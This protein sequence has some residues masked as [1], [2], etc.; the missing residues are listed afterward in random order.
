MTPPRFFA[1][2]LAKGAVRTPLKVW[3]GHPQDPDTGETLTERPAMWRGILDGEP[4][5]MYPRNGGGF[6]LEFGNGPSVE[7]IIV[8]DLIDEDE[9]EYLTQRN[10][11]AREYEP[12]APE[13]NPRKPVNFNAMPPIKWKTGA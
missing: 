9:Y 7:P 4:C 8:G 6:I 10:A 5:D 1:V 12:A 11:H 13:A 3:Y 2:Q